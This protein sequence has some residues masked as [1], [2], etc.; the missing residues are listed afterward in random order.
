MTPCLANASPA[1]PGPEPLPPVKPPPWIQTITGN[2]DFFVAAA[3]A[4]TLRNRQSS[5]MAA[6][7]PGQARCG[8]SAQSLVASRTS[9][10]GVTGCG[11][12]QRLAPT[13]GAAY[14]IPLKAA[15]SP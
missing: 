7:E 10:H 1:E 9:F 12:R 11:G 6:V 2:F 14:G 3:G 5:D 8:Q 13:G 15:T 4:H